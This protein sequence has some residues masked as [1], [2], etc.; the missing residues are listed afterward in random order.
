MNKTE[1]YRYFLKDTIRK[2][3]DFRNTDQHK[4]VPVP[5]VEKPYDSNAHRIPLPRS[6]RWTQNIEKKDLISADSYFALLHPAQILSA[7]ESCSICLA[8]NRGL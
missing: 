8:P 7:R 1:Q 5:P 4:G 2:S 6:D 3:I